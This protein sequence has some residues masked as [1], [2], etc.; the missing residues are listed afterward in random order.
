MGQTEL[1]NYLRYLKPL[2]CEQT[3]DQHYIELLM[4]DNNTWNHLTEYKQMIAELLIL[5]S[6]NWN[7]LTVCKQIIN[8][9]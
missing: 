7:H 5:N 2:N 9:K 8:I 4:L 3:N 1:F 6:N